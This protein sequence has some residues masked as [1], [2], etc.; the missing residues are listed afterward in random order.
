MPKISYCF[1]LSDSPGSFSA[2]KTIYPILLI[3][4]SFSTIC[5][6]QIILPL[7]F[8][9]N[10]D[11]YY[12]WALTCLPRISQCRAGC[13]TYI[14]FK[15]HLQGVYHLPELSRALYNWCILENE[16]VEKNNFGEHSSKAVDEKYTF[17]F[18]LSEVKYCFLEGILP[19]DKSW[20]RRMIVCLDEWRCGS[21]TI[22]KTG[23][24]GSRTRSSLKRFY[25]DGLQ[26]LRDEQEWTPWETSITEF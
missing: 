11:F 8:S 3:G 14:L 4:T 7:P 1:N 23:P 6:S 10:V 15:K 19:G 24:R 17:F 26:R 25:R 9:V 20:K 5:F 22:E 18:F 2:Y 12:S 21:N 16:C 13:N